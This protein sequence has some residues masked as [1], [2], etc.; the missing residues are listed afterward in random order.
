MFENLFENVKESENLFNSLG[1]EEDSIDSFKNYKNTQD[2][3]LHLF[4]FYAP[5]CGHCKHKKQFLKNI[6]N[7]YKNH[8]KVHTYNCERLK[9][10]DS[11][12]KTINGFPTFKMGYKQK[13]HN[14]DLLEFIVVAAAI[15]L[16][17]KIEEVI[18][19]LLESKNLNNDLKSELEN[20]KNMFVRKY[21]N[22]HV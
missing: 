22:I 15:T 12:I 11:Y 2:N 10:S 7:K 14:I 20:K 6:V 19:D 17:L 1:I 21:N 3:K 5:W 13:T 18:K 16:K 9:D 4:M 8:I